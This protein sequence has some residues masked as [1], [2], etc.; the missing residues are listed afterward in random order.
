MAFQYLQYVKEK[1]HDDCMKIFCN[2]L[3][4]HAVEIIIE[5]SDTVNTKRINHISI[6]QIATLA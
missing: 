3:R 1:K 2:E 6:K 4:K 5:K